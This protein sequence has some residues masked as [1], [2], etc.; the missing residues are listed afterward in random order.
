MLITPDVL[1]G[2][3]KRSSNPS[4]VLHVYYGMIERLEAVSVKKET[5]K[6]QFTLKDSRVLLLQ[7]KLADK[8]EEI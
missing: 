3:T 8:L 6:L 2:G 4:G 5:P 1:S 7:C